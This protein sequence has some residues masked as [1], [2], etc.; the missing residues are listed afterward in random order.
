MKGCLKHI[1]HCFRKDEVDFFEEVFGELLQIFFIAFRNNDI[2]DG[3]QFG[4]ED[5][6]L[7]SADG[8]H[9]SS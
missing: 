2:D 3:R 9:A 4:C 8:E 5:F 6:F 7:E 1:I